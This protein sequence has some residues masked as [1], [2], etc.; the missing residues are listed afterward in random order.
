[1][2]IS[3]KFG[4][5]CAQGKALE[6]PTPQVVK[7]CNG[8]YIWCPVTAQA[9]TGSVPGRFGHPLTTHK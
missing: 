3:L 9:T 5:L 1:M 6:W 2:V 8:H 4:G 7:I